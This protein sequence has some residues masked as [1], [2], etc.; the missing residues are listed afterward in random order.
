MFEF[1]F[2]GNLQKRISKLSKATRPTVEVLE[3]REVPATLVGLTT[4][5]QLA[6]F[7]SSTPNSIAGIVPIT[8]MLPGETMVSIDVR[9][10]NGVLYGLGSSSRLY[11]LNLANGA[12]TPVGAGSFTPSLNGAVF[13][14]DFNPTNDIPRVVSN[15]DQNLRLD[16]TSGTV[17]GPNNT[18]APDTSL[19]ESSTIAEIAYNNNTA[20]NTLTTL[21]GIDFTTD[22]L[23]QIGGPGGTPSPNF[24]VVTPIGSLQASTTANV[25]FDI[26]PDGTAYATLSP[27]SGG[28]QLV[29]I[30]LTTGLAS[31]IGTVGNNLTLRGL[32]VMASGSNQQLGGSIHFSQ[33]TYTV[34]QTSPS[35]TVTIVRDGANLGTAA[36]NFSTFDGTAFG[37]VD[38]TPVNQQVVFAAGQVSTTVTIGL[39]S[40][41][42][43]SGSISLNILL[44]NPSAG[45]SLGA[46][47]TGLVTIVAAGVPVN[48]GVPGTDPNG[49]WLAQAYKDLLGRT[50]DPIGQAYWTGVLAQPF[51]S[52]FQVSYGIASSIEYKIHFVQTQYLHYFGTL[53]DAL[54]LSSQVQLM[55]QG[56]SDDLAKATLLGSPALYQQVGG[57]PASFI[58]FL[59]LDLLGRPVDPPGLALFTH[60]LAVN[61][62][63]GQL[64]L[65]ILLTRENDQLEVVRLYQTLLRRGADGAGLT[66]Y[67]DFLQRGIRDEVVIANLVASDEYYQ[68]AQAGF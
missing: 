25:G 44:T 19:T 43:T 24:G 10:F 21:Y 45:A 31:F 20:G 5:S 12:A 27:N 23:V 63:K 15:T 2:D 7:D 28:S 8:G 4:T 16:P 59:Y 62:P 60:A 40:R 55:L 38:Y 34:S 17:T 39:H 48:P 9:P 29:T 67:T 54:T 42:F 58:N 47:A 53:P 3:K 51:A 46:P 11:K 30:N 1:G 56:G 68:N 22:E 14:F 52:R 6:V 66:Y 65:N 18:I 36:V 33:A 61:L 37:N 32:T 64:A 26:A 57:T 50:I 41:S 35:A 49:A 13:G